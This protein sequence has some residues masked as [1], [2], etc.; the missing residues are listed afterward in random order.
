MFPP[1]LAIALVSLAGARSVHAQNAADGYLSAANGTVQAVAIQPDGKALIGGNFT[2][3]NSQPCHSVCRLNADGSVDSGFIDPQADAGV[4]AI[5]L[6]PDGKILV[7]GTF[8]SIGVPAQTRHYLARLNADG[9]VDTSFVD[10]NVSNPVFALALQADGDV[11]VSS[12][13]AV[14]AQFARYDAAGGLDVAFTSTINGFVAAIAV[15]PDGN[16]VLGGNFTTINSAPCN[17]LCRLIQNGDV[18][19]AFADPNA[20]NPVNALALQ[21]NGK[22]L[23]GGNFSMIHGISCARLCL[24]DIDGNVDGS[25]LPGTLAG[26]VSV[27][28][29]QPDGRILA[30][31]TVGT[32]GRVIRLL[33]SGSADPGFANAYTDNAIAAFAL[34][35]DNKILLGGVFT[36]IGNASP[37]QAHQQLARLDANGNVEESMSDA[38]ASDYVTALTLQPDARILVGGA[39][40][41]QPCPT[42]CRLQSDGSVDAGFAV[43]QGQGIIA[44]LTVQADGRILDGGNLSGFAGGQTGENLYR[45]NSN[46]SLDGGFTEPLSDHPVRSIVVQPDG[47]SL[48]SGYF[49]MIGQQTRHYLARLNVNGSV[50]TSF[51]DPNAD[52]DVYTIALQPDGKILVGGAFTTIGM[53]AQ[54]RKFMARLNSNGSLDPGFTGPGVGGG[55]AAAFALQPDGK[56]IVVGFITSIGGDPLRNYIARLNSD[57]SLDPTFTDPNVDNIVYTLALQPNGKTLIGGVFS[58]VGT[59]AQS[60]LYLARLNANGSVD[61]GFANPNANGHVL[62]IALQPDG[63][64]LAGGQF[65]SIGA[66]T[67][68]PRPYL[69]RLSL[70]EAAVQALNVSATGS[71]VTWMRSGAGP[72]LALP[73]LLQYST[74]GQNYVDIGPM[75]RIAGGWT[76]SGVPTPNVVG[77]SYYL[78]ALGRVS[79]G[80]FNASQGL[81]ESVRIAYAGDRIFAN[82]FEP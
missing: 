10:P 32:G 69:A 28:A 17:H 19:A 76:R 51:A 54:A 15:Q 39:G 21:A 41:N 70:P 63:K 68:L 79:G 45:L 64:L 52:S 55:F 16:I 67:A 60:Q 46:G 42:V 13:G 6:Q 72:E 18:D 77:Q 23:A 8:A 20:D 74:D 7:G 35:P 71:M 36:L 30:S 58:H 31:E 34:Q 1:L 80:F 66:P 4:N 26:P 65:T 14:N 40:G 48:I 49:T 27:L 12:Q 11:L 22:I 75:A 2:A 82:G 5:V 38:I 37:T 73:P 53:P 24:L 62:A 44:A 47:K 57:G 29:L 78:R 25:F 61:A 59:P 3:I 9:S 50:D 43:G 81:I 56:I 33:A